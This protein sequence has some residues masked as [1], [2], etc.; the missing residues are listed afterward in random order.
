MIFQSLI[1]LYDRLAKSDDE[2]PPYGFSV[3]DIGFVITIDK[4]GNLI[5]QPEDLRIKIK[6]NTF[7]FRKSV[8][9][10][11]NQVNVRANAAAKTPN[12]MV[13]KA[14]YVFGI[15]G[16]S[17]KDVH[18]ESFR[19]LIDE[20]CCDSQD[21]GILAAKAFL[22]N[23][24]PSDAVEL[25][26]WKEISGAHGKWVAFRLQ[27]DSMFVHERAEVK[28]LWAD[29]V[30]K[31]NFPQGVSLLDGEIHDLQTQYA[32]FKF[33]P[34]ASLVSFNEVAYESYRK[35][36]G[37]N[38]PIS[39][40]A[41]FKSSSALKFLLRSKTQRIR[42]GDAVTVFWAERASPV[43]TFFGQIMNPSVEDM[44]A[45]ITV[46][47][48]LEAVRRGLLPSDLEEDK[49]LKF[50]ILGLSLNK[51]RLALRFWY[52]CSVG[53]LMVR[54]R[55]HFSNL[56]ME[57]S[58]RDIQ[59][60]GVWHLLKETARETK[61]I[62]PVLGG[63]LTRSI[64][65][66]M[67][68]PQNLFQGV[69]GRIR[70]D[71][72]KKHPSSGKPV[73]NVNYLRA[74]ILKAVLQRN[75]KK[76]VPMAL[77]TERREVSYLLGRLF[78]VL[79]KAQLDA[80]GKVNSTIKDRFFSAASATPASVFP[81]LIRLSQRHIE[82]AE[83]GDISDGRIA[84]IMENIESF[85]AHMNLQDQGMFTIAY[86]HQKNAITREIQEAAAKKKAKKSEGEEENDRAN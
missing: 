85:P 71:Q 77:D 51:A 34:G 48:F 8:V 28:K 35:R 67:N 11:T 5:G 53:E 30:V 68:Y 66:G 32:Q 20:V 12:F 33:G 16:T 38:A 76:E 63:S 75:Y 45:A 7:D 52:V 54:F 79:E 39:V 65:T 82:K 4:S 64:L 46:Q 1:T 44:G 72:A 29:F 81:Q 19:K 56:E 9:P 43:E 10:Y 55:D 2:V 74:S 61:N 69:I 58:D 84:G 59:F 14:D 70:A 31:K 41:E 26:H 27:G 86:Y 40:E 83:Y 23:W 17:P 13:D 24:N 47:E 6:A 78:A 60:P 22:I 80:L 42:V 37:E 15:S 50:Y 36:K 73:P 21:A 57:R 62:S 49:N 3:E 25:D 18:H